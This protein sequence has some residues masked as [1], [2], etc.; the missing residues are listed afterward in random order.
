MSEASPLERI[1]SRQLLGDERL[2]VQETLK[3][4][5]YTRSVPSGKSHYVRFGDAIVVWSISANKNIARFVL[6]W[7]GCVWE[8]SRL[9]APDGTTVARR[10]FHS[11]RKGLRKAEIEALGYKEEKLPGKV[12]GD[13]K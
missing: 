8:L 11:E 9:W 12:M 3:R 7:Q 4:N 6:G 2:Q 10:A 1:V 5:H 13:Q